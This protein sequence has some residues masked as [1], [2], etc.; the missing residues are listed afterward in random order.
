VLRVVAQVVAAAAV[1]IVAYVLWFNLTNN[2]RAAGLPTD[3]DFLT[4]P[5][6]VDIAGSDLSSGAPIWRGLLN[7][8]KNTLALVVVGIP[9]LTIIGFVVGVARL[10]T[11]WLVSKAAGLYVEIL[12]NIPPLLIILFVFNAVLLQFPVL[13]DSLNIADLVIINNRYVAV[14]GF[15]A[16]PNF[17]PFLLIMAVALLVAAGVWW[18]RTRRSERT[19]HHH[20]RFIWSFVVFV[21]IS[22]AGFLAL[23]GPIGLSRPVLDGR[24][25]EGGYVG[26]AAYFA[27][28]IA[29]VLYTASHV[30]EIVRGSILAVPKGQTE[31]ANAIALSPFQRLRYVTIPQAMRI[32]IPPIISQY[33]NFTKNTSL[34][35]A[36]GYAEITRI[37]FQTIGNGQPAPQMIA[38]LMGLYLVFSLIISLI[39]NVVNRRMQLVTR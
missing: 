26:L 21:G 2:L 27:V 12:R 23:G 19:G 6:G 36:I 13:Q 16:Q 33:L 3:F 34:A 1:V 38:I 15:T 9:L 17:G 32:A 7:G 29:L 25:L 20:H 11:N 30:A 22:M 39:A 4:Q 18:W 5:L 10:S 14:V 31:A 24:A 37:T 28:L 35:I 8:V